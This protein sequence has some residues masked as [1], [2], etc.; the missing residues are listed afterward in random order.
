MMNVGEDIHEWISQMEYVEDDIHE[1]L[2]PPP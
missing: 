1:M 2:E